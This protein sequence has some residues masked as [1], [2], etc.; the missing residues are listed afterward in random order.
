MPP[1]TAQRKVSQEARELAAEAAE[2]QT[3]T[4]WEPP[5]F[6]HSFPTS[7]REGIWDEH[8]LVEMFQRALDMGAR[9]GLEK[10]AEVAE[11]DELI[12]SE[13]RKDGSFGKTR[14]DHGKLIATAI[15]SLGASK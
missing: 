3:G 7:V 10:A 4:G 6:H 5:F 8:P 1:M 15:R 2:W 14:A 11:S 12:L 13:S 9:R